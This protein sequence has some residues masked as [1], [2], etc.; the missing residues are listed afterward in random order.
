MTVACEH[1][2][3]LASD[4]DDAGSRMRDWAGHGARVLLD[5]D[6]LESALL[7]PASFAEAEAAVLEATSGPDGVLV[8]SAVWE[9]DAVTI[10]VAVRAT[11]LTDE[12]VARVWE[13]LDH[14]LGRLAGYV[15]ATRAPGARGVGARAAT[16]SGPSCPPRP[17]TSSRTSRSTSCRSGSTTIPRSSSTSPTAAADCSKGSGT[18]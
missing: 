7:S 3:T 11:Q 14:E 18:G 13:G 16:C 1:A 2:L 17:A 6:L 4:Y 9:A 5:G 12:L 10:R 15:V 8:A